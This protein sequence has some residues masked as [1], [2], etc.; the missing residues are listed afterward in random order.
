MTVAG[1]GSDTCLKHYSALLLV[2]TTK[3]ISLTD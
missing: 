2:R 1:L 3:D